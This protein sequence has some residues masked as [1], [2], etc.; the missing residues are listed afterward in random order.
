MKKK[1]LVV[2][3]FMVLFISAKAQNYPVVIPPNTPSTVVSQQRTEEKG[4]IVRT[5]ETI[6]QFVYMNILSGQATNSS[7]AGSVNSN[8]IENKAKAYL[9]P[10]ADYQLR[11][12]NFL[13][14]SNTGIIALLPEKECPPI[15]GEKA[16]EMLQRCPAGFVPGNGKYFSFRKKDYV[17]Y[18]L[19]DIGLKDNLLFS[20]GTLNQ[21]ILVA[22]GDVDITSVS[23]DSKGV[24]F[25][26]KFMPSV[27]LENAAKESVQ[28]EKGLKSGDFNYQKAVAVQKDQTF[29]LRVIAYNPYYN[30]NKQDTRFPLKSDSREDVIIVFRVVEK[31]TDGGIVLLWRELRRTESPKIRLD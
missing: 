30:S 20:L 25:L 15:E 24:D 23:L 3:S 28:F 4:R 19:A 27:D 5:N 8:R 22:L 17:D 7:T 18:A 13:Q 16:E 29:A 11:Y 26:A 14:L 10:S 1:L 21:G 12:R 2:L 9:K 31:S 6:N